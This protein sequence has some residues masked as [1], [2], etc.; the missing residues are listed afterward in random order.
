MICIIRPFTCTINLEV[1]KYAREHGCLW[2][3]SCVNAAESGHLDVLMYAR[4]QGCPW[5]K[6]TCAWAAEN[7]HLDVLM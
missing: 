6:D 5:D 3:K 2:N 7:G 1:L 4:E